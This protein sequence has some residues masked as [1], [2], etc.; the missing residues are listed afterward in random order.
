MKNDY[1][2]IFIL[3]L[4]A[5]IILSVSYL[6]DL[7]DFSI[8][9]FFNMITIC[10]AIWGLKFTQMTYQKS[11]KESEQKE[12]KELLERQP[13]FLFKE[14]TQCKTTTNN[15]GYITYGFQYTF[16]MENIGKIAKHL[17][18]SKIDNF[19]NH[20][21]IEDVIIPNEITF[22]INDEAENITFEFVTRS[23]YWAIKSTDFFFSVTYRD[24]FGEERTMPLIMTV[25]PDLYSHINN[26]TYFVKLKDVPK[27]L[28]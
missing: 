26:Q 18:F 11:K 1:A 9:S 10:I 5:I 4:I 3:I 12:R 15:A 7:K 17:S 23:E 14:V 27:E 21:M 13:S 16:S 19:E 2:R 22:L 28:K 20:P 6:F 8:Q 24:I 25:D